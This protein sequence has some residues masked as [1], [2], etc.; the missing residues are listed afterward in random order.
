M[1][2]ESALVPFFFLAAFPSYLKK[3]P[4]SGG[5]MLRIKVVMGFI[6]LAVMLKYLANIDQVMLRAS[7]L[8]RPED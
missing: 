6:L 1:R 3:L 4:R 5:W 7:Y 2:R 8:F